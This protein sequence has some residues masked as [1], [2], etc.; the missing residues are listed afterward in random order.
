[1]IERNERVDVWQGHD[2]V[3]TRAVT[4]KIL[5]A[6]LALDHHYRERFRQESVAAARLSHPNIVSTFDTGDDSGTVYIVTELPKGRPL[7]DVLA[8]E[9]HQQPAVSASVADQVAAALEHAHRAGMVHG[10]VST[11]SI[12]VADDGLGGVRVKLGDFG[13]APIG[14]GGGGAS[15]DVRALAKVLYEMLTGQAPHL[16][17]GAELV[18]PRRL[19]AGIPR[20]LES[21]T[22]RALAPEPRHRFRSAF[23][24]RRSLAALD[25]GPDDAVPLTLPRATPPR[26]TPPAARRPRRTWVP[27]VIFVVLAGAA[28]GVV[29][30]VLG[31]D[32]AGPASGNAAQAGAPVSV[33]SVHSF[34][35]E[36]NPP[37]ENEE[38]AAAAADGN[39]STSWATERYRGANFGHLKSGVG[40]VIRLDGQRRLSR[41]EVTTSSRDWSAAVYVAASAKSKLT[42]WGR[43]VAERGHVSGTTIFN[44][45]S[46]KG[47]VVLLWIT[48]PGQANQFEVTEL[49]LRA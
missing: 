37:T 38:R 16:E 15:E 34:D 46:A 27:L 24:F 40:L 42:D 4:V 9:G 49:A 48:D 18:K 44:L 41:L 26:G 10:A 1:L 31:R 33:A 39:P 17:P 35:P 29:T 12:F 21:I 20:G 32:N 3:L 19:Q 7:A 23:E 13:L 8:G 11:R 25:L 30:W 22:L 5:H 45:Q 43:P 28:A 36:A 6:S 47:G 14:A 2:E